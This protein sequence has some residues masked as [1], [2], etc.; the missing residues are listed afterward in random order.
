M[1]NLLLFYFILIR[2][3]RS[4]KWDHSQAQSLLNII[5]I[6]SAKQKKFGVNH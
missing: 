5:K 4:F 1:C 2:L 3:D 6:K